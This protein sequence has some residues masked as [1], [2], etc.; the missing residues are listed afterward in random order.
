MRGLRTF[1]LIIE[2]AFWS[3]V[4]FLLVISLSMLLAIDIIERYQNKSLARGAKSGERRVGRVPQRDH[5]KE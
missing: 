5:I 2:D 3:G 1:Q 4:V